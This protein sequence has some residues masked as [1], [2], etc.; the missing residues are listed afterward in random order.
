MLELNPTANGVEIIHEGQVV[1]VV[2]PDVLL[3]F[4]PD[5]H[6]QIKEFIESKMANSFLT[7]E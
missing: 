3:A 7:N 6:I 1:C 2:H 4:M 5:A